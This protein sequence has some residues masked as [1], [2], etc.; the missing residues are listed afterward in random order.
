MIISAEGLAR[1]RFDQW[2]RQ[3]NL[4]PNIYA[5]VKGNEAIVSMVSLG[6]G[7]GLV[8]KIV[9]NNSPLADRVELLPE[10][11]DLGPLDRK[12]TRL[13]SS[14]VA[15]SYAVFCLEKKKAEEKDIEWVVRA[16][17]TVT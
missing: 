14:H 9:L 4:Q 17:E 5:E 15:N 13:N 11:P 16:G 12:S 3:Q 8:P 7:V 6:F 10:Q 1:E 2:C